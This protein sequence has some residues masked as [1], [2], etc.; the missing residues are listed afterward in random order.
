MPY[1]REMKRCGVKFLLGGGPGDVSAGSKIPSVRYLDPR[2]TDE[3]VSEFCSDLAGGAEFLGLLFR[4]EIVKEYKREIHRSLIQ[5][6]REIGGLTAAQKITAWE[7]LNR[8]PAFT[9]TSVMHNHPDVSEAFRHF[10]L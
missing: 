6:F 9:F 1:I 7:L 3:C 4:R 8:W 10:R 5:S 2:R